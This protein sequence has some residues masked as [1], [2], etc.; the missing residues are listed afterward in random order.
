MQVVLKSC[1]NCGK[2]DFLIDSFSGLDTL[3]IFCRECGIMYSL[4][5]V[6]RRE[7]ASDEA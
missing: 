2:T 3:H 4:P 7:E 1:P 5:N 6:P